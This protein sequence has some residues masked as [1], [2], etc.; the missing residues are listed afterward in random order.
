MVLLKRQDNKGFPRWQ[1]VRSE[2]ILLICPVKK[3]LR[4]PCNPVNSIA[5][6][7]SRDT[8]LKCSRGGCWLIHWL[9]CER[10]QRAWLAW[11]SAAV[12]RRHPEGAIALS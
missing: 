1:L 5:F 8:V 3:V 11:F 6:S 4:T 7:G 12:W 2:A 9:S 10:R